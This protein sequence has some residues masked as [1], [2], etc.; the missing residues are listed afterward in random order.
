M[1]GENLLLVG[2]LPVFCCN[3]PDAEESQSSG[4]IAVQHYEKDK[5]LD[6]CAKGPKWTNTIREECN[7]LLYD[8][9]SAHNVVVF[10]KFAY[11]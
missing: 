8:K 1:T 11:L 6:P 9:K 10:R 2:F 5:I 4:F 3:V 7:F